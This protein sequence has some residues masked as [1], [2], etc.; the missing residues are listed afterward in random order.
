MKENDNTDEKYSTKK[1]I[2]YSFAG[3]TDVTL[4]DLF[5]SIIISGT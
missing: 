1:A 3:F 5:V 2:F 4:M